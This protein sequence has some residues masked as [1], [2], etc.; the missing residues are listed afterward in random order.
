MPL[1]ESE[2]TV[3][4]R[5]YDTLGGLIPEK[6]DEWEKKKKSIIQFCVDNNIQLYNVSALRMLE[7][8]KIL[9]NLLDSFP[10]SSDEAKQKW[11]E[12]FLL[13]IKKTQSE[14]IQLHEKAYLSVGDQYKKTGAVSPETLLTL[15]DLQ[16]LLND[17]AVKSEH[18]I[19][20]QPFSLT[21]LSDQQREQIRELVAQHHD[22]QKELFLPIQHDGHWFYLL[23]TQE[24]WVLEDS[25]PLINDEFTLRQLDMQVKSRAFLDTLGEQTTS[26]QFKTSGKQQNDYDCG[27]QVIN[28]YRK[29]VNPSYIEKTHHEMLQELVK[30]QCPEEDA[31]P[32]EIADSNEL[33]HPANIERAL[34]DTHENKLEGKGNYLKE[35]LVKAKEGFFNIKEKDK[36]DTAN[37]DSAE[38]N[39]GESDE[40]FAKRLQEAELRKAGY[41]K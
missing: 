18:I 11:I 28:A 19:T 22:D 6:I 38:H 1:L 5:E 4:D 30:K 25:Q 29:K 24:Q 36:I 33:L 35:L 10:F 21:E 12:Q 17:P 40:D 15:K 31:H 16:D 20:T 2:K 27:T 14:L 26:L 7:G 37:I 13:E 8:K 23:K 34:P 32:F 9:T 41:M 39:P 3:L